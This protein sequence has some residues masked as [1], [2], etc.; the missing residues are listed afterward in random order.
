MGK[1]CR[2]ESLSY[3]PPHRRRQQS[4]LCDGHQHQ[5]QAQVCFPIIPEHSGREDS[6]GIH[7]CPREPGR[8]DRWALRGRRLGKEVLLPRV[9]GAGGVTSGAGT[10]ASEGSRTVMAVAD[11]EC[12]LGAGVVHA[13]GSAPWDGAWFLLHLGPVWFLLHLGPVPFPC[14]PVTW[15]HFLLGRKMVCSR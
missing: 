8:P 5:H 6:S 2:S 3:F 14:D 10:A 11:T 1:S 4:R 7:C 15:G 9:R 12:T 13:L